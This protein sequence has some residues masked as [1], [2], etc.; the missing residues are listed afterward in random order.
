MTPPS[1]D[2]LCTVKAHV[3]IVALVALR[4]RVGA[5]LAAALSTPQGL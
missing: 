3:T 1:D 5:D 2:T 4:N